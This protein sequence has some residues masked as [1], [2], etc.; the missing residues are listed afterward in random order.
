MLVADPAHVPG[1]VVAL[2]LL[3]YRQAL[4]RELDVDG[5]LEARGDE[6]QNVPVRDGLGVHQYRLHRCEC[7]ALVGLVGLV[8]GFGAISWRARRSLGGGGGERAEW[9]GREG[10]RKGGMR[11]RNCG[12]WSG[13][14]T[15]VRPRRLGWG[16]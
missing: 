8:V 5:V 14:G 13:K 4:V 7:G 11:I 12:R 3:A 6:G 15:S 2:A 9:R 10:G 1:L 16:G